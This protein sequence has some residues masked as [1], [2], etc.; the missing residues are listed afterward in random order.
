MIANK[1]FLDVQ[2]CSTC[3]DNA[4]QKLYMQTRS[5]GFTVDELD[6]DATYEVL[7]CYSMAVPRLIRNNSEFG[8][9]AQC[10]YCRTCF[11]T[12]GID[13]IPC[14]TCTRYP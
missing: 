7:V 10:G 3:S 5:S 1:H 4:C 9:I 8:F 13:I 2:L 11:S 12:G 14:Y 6:F